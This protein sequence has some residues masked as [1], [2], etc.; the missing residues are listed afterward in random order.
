MVMKFFFLRLLLYIDFQMWGKTIRALI[1]IQI[2]NQAL[3]LDVGLQLS[4]SWQPAFIL[5]LTE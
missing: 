4:V 1:Q 3:N 2:D 5:L